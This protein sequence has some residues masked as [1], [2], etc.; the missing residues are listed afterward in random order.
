MNSLRKFLFLTMYN[1]T[2][3]LTNQILERRENAAYI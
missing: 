1:P 3:K 2:M